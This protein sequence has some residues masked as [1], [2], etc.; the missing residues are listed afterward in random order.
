MNE[1]RLT[2]LGKAIAD[3]RETDVEKLVSRY[4][5]EKRP[6]LEIISELSAGM[7]VV[8]S[9]FKEGEYY[10]SELVF[11]GEIFQNSMARLKPIID[12]AGGRECAGKVI[13]GT[14]KGDIH[15]LGKDIVVTLLECA[16]FEV[17]NLGV[18]VMPEKFVEALRGSQAPLL[19]LSGLITTAFGSMK[20]TID[21]I[22]SAGL[23][24]SVKIMI[25]GGPTNE[26]VKNH[27]GADFYGKDAAAAVDI[28]KSV[29]GK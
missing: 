7:D 17:M 16:G 25:G 1:P 27:V 28:A 5:D 10:L 21:A 9:L 23:R 6:P 12:A 24:D 22:A 18:D 26:E 2:E 13:M 19:G 11:S 15:N 29:M 14:V 20:E 4:I 8:G 3:L